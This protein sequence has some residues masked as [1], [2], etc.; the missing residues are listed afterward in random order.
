MKSKSKLFQTQSIS[1]GAKQDKKK[2]SNVDVVKQLD[3]KRATK[4]LAILICQS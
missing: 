1:E 3:S 2:A 4:I